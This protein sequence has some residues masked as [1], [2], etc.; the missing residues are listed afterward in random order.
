MRNF[1]LLF[2]LALAAAPTVAQTTNVA[3]D[4]ELTLMNGVGAGGTSC[5][6]YANQN[7]GSTLIMH[8]DAL[9][10]SPFV[11]AI[12]GSCVP[13]AAPL[14]GG[15]YLDL[16][17]VTLAFLADGTGSLIPSN[18]LT[19]YFN[20]GSQGSGSLGVP[21]LNASE[22][23]LQY[24]YVNPTYPAGI[25][26]SA[27]FD[28]TFFFS[29]ICGSTPVTL[30]DDDN[31]L[32]STPLF[33]FYSVSY[34]DFYINSNGSLTFGAGDNDFT[35]T[36]GEFL[37][38]PPRIS[39]WWDDLNPSSAGSVHHFDNGIGQ[40][41]VCFD[42]VPEFG[43]PGPNNFSTF[44]T[45]VQVDLAYGQMASGD[46]LV[47]LSPG[48]NMDPVGTAVDFSAGNGLTFPPNTAVYEVFDSTN[49]PDL[50]FGTVL[51]FTLTL[52]GHPTA[53]TLP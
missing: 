3:G 17:P 18:P 35:E 29:G 53:L 10:G 6:T 27:A 41:G 13:G 24:G 12:A 33:F 16:D 1:T 44:F 43:A 47:G 19:P 8:Y 34:T 38:G 7:D 9:P 11:V 48:G 40:A 30:G 22:F 5:I 49:P 15:Y 25:G 14:G 4:N 46:G 36:V 2:V 23:S 20:T 45:N 50:S 26:T 28:I 37:S 31:I 52:S 51:H 42:G 32:V 21:N 39:M